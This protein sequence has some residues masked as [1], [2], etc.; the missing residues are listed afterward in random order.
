MKRLEE[1]TL[2][3]LWRLFSIRLSA[4]DERWPRIAEEE[5]I[6]LKDILG[7]SMV[8][9]SHIG[10]T[11]INGIKAKP[12]IDLLVEAPESTLLSAL[13]KRISD[14]GY[15]CMNETADRISFN[16]GYTIDGYADKVYHLHL[17][18]AG[19]NDEI[20]FRDYLN[21]HPSIAAEYEMLKVR[22]SGE[23]EYNR[24]AYTE[25]KTDFV[26]YYTDIAVK[27]LR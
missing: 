7:E 25:A 11:A 23:Y 8:R 27:T 3:E 13:K 16:R 6:R 21:Q 14:A 5:I 17:R 2:E 9:I 10:S 26:R 1:L 22:L 19:D 15:L 24:D 20:Y 12:I 18:K 4:Y